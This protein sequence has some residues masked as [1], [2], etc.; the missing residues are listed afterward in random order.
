MKRI[1]KMIERLL[2]E[3]FRITDTNPPTM[4]NLN[5][6]TSMMMSLLSQRFTMTRRLKEK[7]QL[8]MRKSTLSFMERAKL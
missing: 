6:I 8:F 3:L 2:R 1:L 7:A 5:L 4:N